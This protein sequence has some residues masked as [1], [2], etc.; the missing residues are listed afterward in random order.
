VQ[1]DEDEMK[2]EIAATRVIAMSGSGTRVPVR[3]CV[4]RPQQLAEGDWSCEV[5]GGE[6][7]RGPNGGVRGSDS[8]QALALAFYLIRKQLDAFRE[9]GGR[10][11][12]PSEKDQDEECPLDQM[13]GFLRPT[14]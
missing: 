12:Q 9:N 11:L 4:Y 5:E 14:A 6:L 1:K 13:C 2:E 10:L 3:I 7:L 8:F